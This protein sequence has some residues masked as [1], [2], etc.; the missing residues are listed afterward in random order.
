MALLKG[1]IMRNTL[2]FSLLSTLL[3]TMLVGNTAY[4]SNKNGSNPSFSDKDGNF[5]FVEKYDDKKTESKE[6]KQNPVDL[7]LDEDKLEFLDEFIDE[8]KLEFL[9]EFSDE[10][11]LEFLDEF[12][13]EDKLEFSGEIKNSPTEQEYLQNEALTKKVEKFLKDTKDNEYTSF[14]DKLIG[15]AGKSS[16]TAE[17]MNKYWKLK[18]Q[19]EKDRKKFEE[20]LRKERFEKEDYSD[21][22]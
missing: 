6:K 18:E 12:I 22:K 5:T 1:L 16:I 9:D 4:S 15:N 8:D 2:K 7:N 14:K 3:C 13:D 21:L 17:E 19:E 10:D 20:Y 11:K